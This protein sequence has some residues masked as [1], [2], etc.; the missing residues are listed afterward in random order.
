VP[1]THRA[2]VYQAHLRTDMTRVVTYMSGSESNGLAIPEIGI[3]CEFLGFTHQ[4]SALPAGPG[5]VSSKRAVNQTKAR[6]AIEC[7]IQLLDQLALSP[8]FQTRTDRA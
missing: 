7:G 2:L 8:A 4:P 6:Q 5:P 3:G 1:A